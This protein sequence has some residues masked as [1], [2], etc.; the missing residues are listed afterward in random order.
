MSE[1][2]I[3]H[4]PRCSKSRQTLEMLNEK[5]IEPEIIEYLSCPLNSSE[6]ETLIQK[7]GIQAQELLRTKEVVFKTLDINLE[8][9]KQVIAAMLEHRNLIERPI[10]VRGDKA[11]LGRPPENINN[12]F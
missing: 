9:S 3:Y 1:W 10:V 7:L 2:K 6:L 11:V 8:D 12:L 5:G 4:N